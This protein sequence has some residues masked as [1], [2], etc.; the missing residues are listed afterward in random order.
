MNRAEKILV[1]KLENAFGKL[2]EALKKHLLVYVLSGWEPRG[3]RL[4]DVARE[5]ETRAARILFAMVRAGGARVAGRFRFPSDALAELAASRRDY[6]K[7]IV[8]SALAEMRRE[9]RSIPR[10]KAQ[11]KAWEAI[12]IGRREAD[13]ARSRSLA[14]LEKAVRDKQPIVGGGKFI[15][16]NLKI[17]SKDGTT[18]PLKI[19]TARGPEIRNYDIGYYADLVADT[20][21]HEAE[22]KALFAAAD[23]L[24][25]QLVKFNSKK[26]DYSSD[27]VCARI[28]G[29][30]FS[31]N[32]RG[33]LGASGTRYPYLYARGKGLRP[34]WSTAHPHCDHVAYPIAKE[35]A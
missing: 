32:P 2:G 6:A 17:L 16:E 15:R 24:G 7:G 28:D 19:N 10:T 33:S 34:G 18:F 13:L 11:T 20:T 3:S 8:R 12:G 4:D 29:K 27:P 31:L 23:E 22:Q 14:A 35:L 1:G 9:L 30:I 5:V 25:T 21:Y 26:A